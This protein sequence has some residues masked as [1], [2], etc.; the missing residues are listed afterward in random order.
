MKRYII[1]LLLLLLIS[2]AG[3]TDRAGQANVTTGGD[4][5]GQL[6][7]ELFPDV[8]TPY[9]ILDTTTGLALISA[10]TLDVSVDPGLNAVQRDTTIDVVTGTE[11]YALPSDFYE[12][13]AGVPEFGVTAIPEDEALETG[14]EIMSVG[15][16]GQYRDDTGIPL[17]FLV[18]KN[19]LHIEPTNNT[20]DT[21]RVYYAAYSNVIDAVTDT[22][23]ID[24]R[25]INYVV[26]LSAEK[27]LQGVFSKGNQSFANNKLVYIASKQQE[28]LRKL[29]VVDK[30]P[31]DKIIK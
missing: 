2:S 23:N 24:K 11:W 5:L 8:S 21:V 4:M 30:A 14:M 10:A 29:G 3:A 26:L 31:I 20:G 19:R 1:P 12:I 22:T 13:P 7:K 27:Y 9:T 15:A 16:I 28:A 25:Y 17:H 6:Y 18:R